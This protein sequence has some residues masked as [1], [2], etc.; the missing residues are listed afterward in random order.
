M[1][2]VSLILVVI[3]SA[4][5]ITLRLAVDEYIDDQEHELHEMMYT[6]PTCSG[7]HSNQQY[8]CVQTQLYSNVYKQSALEAFLSC[9]SA[10]YCNVE[11]VAC[12]LA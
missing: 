2:K 10:R 4:V 12:P 6:R 8:G 1:Q 5:S 7:I 11:G 3:R 9:S